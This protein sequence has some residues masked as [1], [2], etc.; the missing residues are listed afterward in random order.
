MQSGKKLTP[1][2]KYEV[3]YQNEEYLKVSAGMAYL[4]WTL[5][6]LT[7]KSVLDVGC[8]AGYTLP[9]FLLHNKRVQGIEV[10]DYLLRTTLRTYVVASLVK[11]GR[12]QEIPHPESSFDLVYCT[13]VMEHIPECDIHQ[14]I[15]ELVR[16][17]KKYILLTISTQPARC[18]PELK[19][20][21]TVK[22]RE[23][24]DEQ[25]NQFRIKLIDEPVLGESK[26]EDGFACVYAKY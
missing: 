26:R 2:E 20:H 18:F 24:W 4:T 10:C 19:L 12:I 14:S 21:E 7:F 23:W 16:V 8:G 9:A 15:S 22:K 11:K 5:R 13:E 3:A 1:E 17:S 6:S 25:F